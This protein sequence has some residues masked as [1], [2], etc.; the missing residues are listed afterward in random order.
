MSWGYIT[1][2]HGS[3][4]RGESTTCTLGATTQRSNFHILH[5]H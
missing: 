5:H 1:N 3:S 4:F 2:F